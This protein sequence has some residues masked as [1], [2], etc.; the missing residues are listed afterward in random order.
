MP[1]LDVEAMHL[2][3]G[4]PIHWCSLS[5]CYGVW[6]DLQCAVGILDTVDTHISINILDVLVP[7]TRKKITDI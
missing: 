7:H 1:R 4:V 5:D 6:V 3:L 2:F